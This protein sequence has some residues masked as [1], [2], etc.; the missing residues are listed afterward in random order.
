M[1]IDA[2]VLIDFFLLFSS[3]LNGAAAA[4]AVHSCPPGF[5]L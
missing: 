5:A 2:L 1:N 3:H 4:V